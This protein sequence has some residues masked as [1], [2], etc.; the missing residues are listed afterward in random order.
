[1]L[2]RWFNYFSFTIITSKFFH[3]N[4][5]FKQLQ[6]HKRAFEGDLGENTG[7]MGAIAPIIVSQI[8]DEKITDILQK[9]IA[10]L[11]KQETS[12]KGILN[13]NFLIILNLGILYAGLMI[14]KSGPKVLEFNCRFGDPET[15]VNF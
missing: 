2:Y 8:I 6:D 7:G 10:A 13:Y 11:K 4:I 1:M 12:Y 3:L 14:T 9:T 15:E 5:I